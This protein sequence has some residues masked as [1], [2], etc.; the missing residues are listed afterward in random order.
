[1]KQTYF[2]ACMTCHM[3]ALVSEEKEAVERYGNTYLYERVA[4]KCDWA[5]T[6]ADYKV[7]IC[8]PKCYPECYGPGGEVGILKDEYKHLMIKAD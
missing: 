1:M 6:C 8:C 3:T 4:R 7:F 5:M 2:V